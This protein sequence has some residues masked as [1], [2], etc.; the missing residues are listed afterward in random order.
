M[1]EF[2]F[3]WSQKYFY[4]FKIDFNWAFDH[5]CYK[6]L[7]CCPSQ[8]YMNDYLLPPP[9]CKMSFVLGKICKMGT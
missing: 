7:C 5:V 2:E 4:L 1:N 8:D 9:I 3:S 6:L